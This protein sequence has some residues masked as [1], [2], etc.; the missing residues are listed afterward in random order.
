MLEVGQ[1]DCRG[2]HVLIPERALVIPPLERSSG[3]HQLSITPNTPPDRGKDRR[4]E[5]VTERVPICL[6]QEGRGHMEEKRG[7]SS[8]LWAWTAPPVL[9]RA[10]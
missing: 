4:K 10:K 6:S 8:L 2:H 3:G 9:P 1:G 7:L 5:K